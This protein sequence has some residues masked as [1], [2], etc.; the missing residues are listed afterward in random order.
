M[1]DRITTILQMLKGARR[2]WRSQL[3]SLMLL[4]LRVSK[5]SGFLLDWDQSP[6]IA[7]YLFSLPTCT[8][9]NRIS[10]VHLETELL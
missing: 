7:L 1:R 3:L 10:K 5:G 9:N 2:R 4:N 6:D 8:E